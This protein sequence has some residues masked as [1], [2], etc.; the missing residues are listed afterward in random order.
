MARALRVQFPGAMYHVTSR[1]VGHWRQEHNRLFEDAADYQRFLDR[2]AER[3]KQFQI[4][5]YLY[6]LMGS[7]SSQSIVCR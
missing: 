1:M 3:V 2:L 5:L 7:K 6:R 4:R